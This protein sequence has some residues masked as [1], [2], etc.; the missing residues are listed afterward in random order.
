MAARRASPRGVTPSPADNTMKKLNRSFCINI[1]LV[2]AVFVGF[3]V[4][5]VGN[6]G[7]EISPDE[8]FSWRLTVLPSSRFVRSVIGDVHPPLYYVF[9]R[10][11]CAGMGHSLSA[12]RT[13]SALMGAATIAATYA[14]VSTLIRADPRTS[15]RPETARVAGLLAAILVALS[16]FQVAYGRSARMYA[17][18]TCL[19]ALSTWALLKSTREDQRI[20]WCLLYS[21]SAAGLA[22]THYY[23]IFTI[24]AHAL[25]V[26]I[27]LLRTRSMQLL[28]NGACA[29]SAFLLIYAGWMPSMRTQMQSV[30]RDYWIPPLSIGNLRSAAVY[31]ATGLRNIGGPGEALVWLGGATLVL[32]FARQRG[33]SA[34]ALLLGLIGMPWL[35]AIG[36]AATGR[37]VFLERYTI[38]SQM[39]ALQALAIV[40]AGI[41]GRRSRLFVSTLLVASSSLG[42]LQEHE[43]DSPREPR[44]ALEA[45]IRRVASLAPGR[46]SI[47]VADGGTQCCVLFYV[48]R[49]GVD[50][51]VLVADARPEGIGHRAYA[52][53]VSD[54]EWVG[55]HVISQQP[56]EYQYYLSKGIG[57]TSLPEACRLPPERVKSKGA[58]DWYIWQF[59]THPDPTI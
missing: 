55:Y 28:R 22:L 8:A 42:L 12:L 1:G 24:I 10:A 31:G 17:M 18:G 57:D 29:A 40:L 21:A 4:R 37:S 46:T 44:G 59:A 3:A 50:A 58:S 23:G 36:I 6:E 48:V 16:P 54:D 20:R 26:A 49:C 27:G 56:G 9:L 2:L 45:A 30:W 7:C 15:D 33:T 25:Y 47:I 14:C 53:V 5:T 19:S 41:P 51:R 13:F 39:F 43:A 52:S 32:T 11:W 35:G 38:F 34:S